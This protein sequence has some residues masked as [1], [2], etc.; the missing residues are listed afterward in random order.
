MLVFW[1][2]PA[3]LLKPCC[4]LLA[5]LKL[6]RKQS[7]LPQQRLS[8]FVWSLVLPEF[9]GW[10]VKW[11]AIGCSRGCWCI[12]NPQAEV[13]PGEQR[14]ALIPPQ[15][16]LSLTF[17]FHYLCYL[18]PLSHMK[19]TIW[20]RGEHDWCSVSSSQEDSSAIHWRRRACA[21]L[22]PA[23][24]RLDTA[25]GAWRAEN[26][27]VPAGLK[28]WENSLYS[29]QCSAHSLPCPLCS[30]ALQRDGDWPL[31]AVVK[32]WLCLKQGL[33]WGVV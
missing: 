18:S 33:A 12:K 24:A 5:L 14:E 7:C 27:W 8:S 19:A 9:L 2:P 13:V 4:V 10:P 32:I 23:A 16:F 20:K 26:S 6:R 1:Y 15:W 17:V 29:I 31:N 25:V 28:L 22:S 11:N 30:P 21:Q 3:L